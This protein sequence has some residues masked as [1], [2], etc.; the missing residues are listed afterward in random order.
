MAYLTLDRI[1]ATLIK[2]GLAGEEQ[3]RLWLQ[4]IGAFTKDEYTIISLPH[5]FRVRGVKI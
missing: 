3:I 1:K 4:E 5:I 2:Q